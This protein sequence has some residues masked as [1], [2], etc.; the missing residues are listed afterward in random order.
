MYMALII[1]PECGKEISDRAA[2]CPNCGVPINRDNYSNK[3]FCK[4]CGTKIDMECVVCPSCGKQVEE[5]KSSDQNQ[6]IIV[7]NNSSSSS[8][9]ITYGGSLVNYVSP[10]SRLLAL[11]LCFFL[12]WLGIH[13][14]YVGKSG[15]AIL[16][17]LLMFTGIG[18]IWLFIDLVLILLGAFSDSLGL[19]LKN[20]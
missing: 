9:A 17:I 2:A 6:N 20:W 8:N 13:R 10:K 14:F 19:K 12:G 16:M 3:K 15:T 5:L 11:L 7:N 18:E 4:F 1:C